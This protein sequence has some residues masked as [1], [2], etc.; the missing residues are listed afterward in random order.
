MCDINKYSTIYKDIKK[1]TQDDT[2][3]LVLEAPS[4]EE[5][6]FYVMISDYFLQR[7]QKECIERNVF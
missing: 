5:K 7:N 4:D 6:D 3:Q 1:L 2:M